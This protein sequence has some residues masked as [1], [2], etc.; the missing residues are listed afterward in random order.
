VVRSE[1]QTIRALEQRLAWHEA[2]HARL[3][4]VIA[5]MADRVAAQPRGEFVIGFDRSEAEL[6]LRALHNAGAMGLLD[7]VRE[8]LRRPL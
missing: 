8:A 4:N 5:G 3:M 2:E 1:Q 7:R 6:L